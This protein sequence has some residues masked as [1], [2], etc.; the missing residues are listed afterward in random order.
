MIRWVLTDCTFLLHQQTTSFWDESI[1]NVF[2]V[3]MHFLS[4]LYVLLCQTKL[5]DLT[6]LQPH[7]LSLQHKPF[8][9]SGQNLLRYTNCHIESHSRWCIWR[10]SVGEIS[11][12]F[13]SILNWDVL[14]YSSLHHCPHHQLPF[15]SAEVYASVFNLLFLFLLWFL[16]PWSWWRL[17]RSLAWLV[18]TSMQVVESNQLDGL[19]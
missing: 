2:F 9:T 5:C 3:W 1:G 10:W 4:L 11:E 6:L 14:D 15:H 19:Q 7:F 17:R 18:V 16:A 12:S 8:H 13:S